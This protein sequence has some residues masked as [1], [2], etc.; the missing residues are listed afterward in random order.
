MPTSGSARGGTG[1]GSAS[2][3]GWTVPRITWHD[4]PAVRFIALDTNCLAGGAAGCL[5]RDQARW[6]NQAHRGALGVPRRRNRSEI[7]VGHDDRLVILFS[8]HGSGTLDNSRGN[9]S[10]PGG[11]RALS[12]RPTCSPCCTGSRTW[13][14]G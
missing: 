9:H 13:S 14:C 8:H 1:T 10:G 6:L 2:V 5:D 11:E 12:A 4:T 7:Q 3:T